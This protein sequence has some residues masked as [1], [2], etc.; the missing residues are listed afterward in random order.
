MLFLT[1]SILVVENFGVRNLTVENIETFAVKIA[2][3]KILK[4]LVK[5]MSLEIK[6]LNNI[7]D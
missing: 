2:D 3:V 6:T 1:I 4:Q 5:I 7:N